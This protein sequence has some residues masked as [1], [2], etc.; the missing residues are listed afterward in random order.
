MSDPFHQLDSTLTQVWQRLARGTKDRRAATR[1]PTLATVGN[2]GPQARTVV[3]RAVDPNAKTVEI[4][5]DR[6]S[7]KVAE[8][9]KNPN[10][11]LHIWDAK[12]NLQIRL[13]CTATLTHADAEKWAQIPENAQRAYGGSPAPGHEIPRPDAHDPAPNRDDFTTITLHITEIETLHLGSDLHRRARFA[14]PSWQGHWI[15][16]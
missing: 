11:A 12:A 8:L 14:A 10:A 4:H 13:R 1:N 6:R 15:A 7:L 2:M 16:P 5:T 9:T 3:L